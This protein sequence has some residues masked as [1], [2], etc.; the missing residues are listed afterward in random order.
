MTPE[1]QRRIL[2]LAIL[3]LAAIPRLWAAGWNQG[4]FWPD[5]IFQS[6]EP[7]H[8]FAFGYG[9]VPWEFDEGARSWLLPGLIGLFWK[10]LAALGVSTA[11]SFV[12]AAKLAVASLGLLG[13]YASM[14]LADR[15][16]GPTAMLL[17]GVLGASFPP[18][19]IFGSRCL[20][21]TASAPLCMVALLL[22]YDRRRSRLIL[23]GGLSVVA[24]YLRYQCGVF[25]LGL[26]I[27]LLA[28]R[29]AHEAR[30]FG[31]GA[32]LAG[33]GG[34]LL[35]V[36]TWGAP[37][38]SLLTYLRFNLF[39]GR[40]A[41]F[42][43]EP[44]A[45][46]ITTLWSS[47][48]PALL[49]IA[50]GLVACLRRHPGLLAV[51]VLFVAVHSAIGHKELRFLMPIFPLML[52]L[53]GVGLASLM[54]PSSAST[55][56]PARSRRRAATAT[57]PERDGGKIPAA[58]W[59]VSAVLLVAMG[60]RTAAATFDDLGQRRG[61]FAG[62]RSVWHAA[63]PVNRLLWFVGAR[64]DLC[65]LALIGYGPVWTG[66]FSYLHRD[67]P[68]VWGTPEE[69]LAA[70][71]LGILGEAANYVLTPSTTALPA[72]YATVATLGETKLAQRP[73]SCKAGAAVFSRHFP[74]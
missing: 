14:R 61:L 36:V 66:G 65:G 18:S 10:M 56:P 54:E 17:C 59:V 43:T 4:I 31:G 73:G 28:A 45:F 71:R 60:W 19:I 26:L 21:E 50:A 52:T 7:A 6:L 39:E 13:L 41:D 46:Y 33:L 51:L 48:G 32:L 2:P 23:A 8:G 55:K 44:V 74:K 40:A 53:A 16:A 3:L 22:I 25:A 58:A 5:E 24:V 70:P 29:R 30:W 68:V 57:T 34:M 47:T 20:G 63:E 35:D 9:F 1:T 11:P 12:I 37:F 38:H 15:L 49:V 62:P 27:W 67:V 72:E 42:G 69:A 64:A